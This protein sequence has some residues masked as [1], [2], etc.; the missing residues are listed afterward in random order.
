MLT[1]KFPL[2]T[3]YY[4]LNAAQYQTING[5]I[6]PN[7]FWNPRHNT[8]AKVMGMLATIQSAPSP[9]QATLYDQ[10]AR[11]IASDGLLLTPAIIQQIT[12]YSSHVKATAVAGVPVPMVYDIL[13]S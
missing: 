8:D 6:G 9:Q 2:I 11:Q 1:G 7:G 3:G 13:P 10:L 5:I 4:T 12:V